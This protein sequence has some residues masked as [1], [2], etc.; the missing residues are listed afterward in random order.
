MG[1]VLLRIFIS[2]NPEFAKKHIRRWIGI[3]T[4]WQ[5]SGRHVQALLRG[6][7]FGM[8]SFMLAD[9]T[10]WDITARGAHSFWYDSFNFFLMIIEFII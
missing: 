2:M 7:R 1:G 10:M 9:R 3:S 5:G 6:Y 8:P 4:P